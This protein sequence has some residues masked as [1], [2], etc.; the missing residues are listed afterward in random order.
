MM[1]KILC[2][3]L[4]MSWYSVVGQEIQRGDTARLQSKDT[5]IQVVPQKKYIASYRPDT[6]KREAPSSVPAGN[7]QLSAPSTYAKLIKPHA[8]TRKGLFTVHRV[9]DN[10][11]F[12]IP[13]SLLGRDLLVV[14]RIA[15]GAAGVRPEYTGY[16]GDQVGSTI[17]RFERGPNHKLFLRRITYEENPGDSTNAMFHAV[18]RS[19]LQPLVAAFG[20]GAYA[21]NLRG[22]VIDITDYINGDNDILFFNSTARKTMRVGSMQSNMCYIKDINSFPLNLEIRTIKTYTQTSSDNNF[23]L[24]LNTS[25]VLLP[26]KPMRKRFADRRVGYFTERYVDY[27][28][29]PQGVK[30]VNYIKR[31]RLEP[32]PQDMAKYKSGELVEPQKPIIYYIDPATPKKWV[33]YLMQGVMDWQKAFEKA[34]FKNAILAKEAP[35]PREQPNWSLEDSRHSAI[36]YKPSSFANA[37]GPIITD[38]RSGEILESHINWYHN[39]MSILREWYMVQCGTTDPRAQ[40]MKF[41][42]ALMGQ[43]IRSV[44]AHEVGHSLGLTHN[45]GSSSTV[46]VEKLRD[47]EWLAVHGHTPSIMDY[48]RFNYVA[49]P[50]DSVGEAG[51]ISRIGDYD[52]WAI[53]YG[54]R[55]LP[56]IKS[57]ENEIPFLNGWIMD[58]MKDKRL[59]FGSEF[60]I[61]DPRIQTEDLGDNAMK[62]GDYGIKNL[63]RIVPRLIH[64][65]YE[66]NEGYRNLKQLYAGVI[67]QYNFYLGHVITYIGGTFETV[68]TAEQVGPVYSPVPGSLQREAVQFLSRHVFQTP[69]WL[70]DTALLSR[71]GQSPEQIVTDAHRM[72]L[73][74]ILSNTTLN[75]LQESE[76]MYGLKAYRFLDLLDDVDKEIW[77][78]LNTYASISIY[79]RNL[80][81]HYIERLLEL[82][83]PRSGWDTRD[84]GPV[85]ANKLAEIDLR[86]DKALTKTKDAMT[87]YHLRYIQD[88]IKATK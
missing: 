45:F 16:A 43:L 24:E 10:Y 83:T 4:L 65:T 35:D 32:K 64:W 85:V 22:S 27:D 33:P 5:A 55:L 88:K 1:R 67:N 75:K 84:V 6:T 79:R 58:K 74:N 11:Y 68:K 56:E 63:Q 42:D 69:T 25:I 47:R 26:K 37:A 31:W 77:T 59:W 48:S 86:I 51:L 52:C 53:E 2:Y 17:I 46:P 57:E 60:T 78:E 44:C 73:N 14:T 82:A 23:T 21:L 28:A 49:Q 41:D 50:E 12:E 87:V 39:L 81:R 29:N 13:D 76:A 40:K 61:D 9:D 20:V 36:V 38:P 7:D 8:L 30:T 80:Q 66:P 70:L 62:A 71:T 18:V 15:Q 3:A 34:G 72:A 54:Y 19:N